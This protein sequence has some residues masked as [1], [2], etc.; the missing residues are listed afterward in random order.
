MSFKDDYKISEDTVKSPA[1]FALENDKKQLELMLSR[2][3][4]SKEDAYENIV[5]MERFLSY[6]HDNL[7]DAQQKIYEK[8]DAISRALGKDIL[9]KGIEISNADKALHEMLVT[10]DVKTKEKIKNEIINNPDLANRLS[11]LRYHPEVSSKQKGAIVGYE[12]VYS[13]MVEEVRENSTPDKEKNSNDVVI[14]LLTEYDRTALETMLNRELNS[15][16]DAYENI[17]EMELFLSHP[18]AHIPEADDKIDEKLEAIRNILG[19]DVLEKGLEISDMAKDQHDSFVTMPFEERLKCE[20]EILE[21]PDLA[22]QLSYLRYHPEISMKQSGPEAMIGH[23][24]VYSNMVEEKN[25]NEYHKNNKEK[26]ASKN[27]EEKAEHN[28]NAR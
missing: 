5:E 2:E 16:E 19:Q 22:E 27:K 26:L 24:A 25:A 12:A 23:K 7:P 1:E 13:N 3:L 18:H 10:M 17:V 11:Y 14:D 6:P 4:N 8:Y 28:N 21:N 20:K 9:D 15:K